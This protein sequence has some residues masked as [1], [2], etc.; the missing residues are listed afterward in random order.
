MSIT[1]LTSRKSYEKKRNGDYG[2][3]KL[4]PFKVKVTLP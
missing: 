4:H 2:R 1:K 3:G